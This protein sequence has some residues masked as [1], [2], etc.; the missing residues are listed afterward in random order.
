MVERS[1]AEQAADDLCR[2][3]ENRPLIHNITNYVVM[4]VTANALLA[5]GA[6]P[7]MAHALE[8]VEEMTS[9]A[10]ALVLNIGTLSPSWIEAMIKAGKRARALGLPVVLDPVGAGA[11]RLRTETARRIIEEVRPQVIRGNASEILALIG[12]L[13]G[14]GAT[15]G[16]DSI[17]APEEAAAGARQSAK[18][19]KTVLAV[20]GPTDWVTDGERLIRVQNGHE[21]MGRITGSGC[22]ATALIGA[23]L[24]VNNDPL[25]AVV[26][27]LACYG[28]AGETA[29]LKAEGPGTFQAAILDALYQMEE[30]TLRAKARIERD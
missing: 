9:L 2:I 16:V 1:L 11:T 17:H 3:R 12:P 8:E 6:S 26:G 14:R 19:L 28:L 24:A 13:E 4:N 10:R 30:N 29:A 21:M 27:A 22:T 7:V 5:L 20:T 15:K 23:F 18:A 25:S